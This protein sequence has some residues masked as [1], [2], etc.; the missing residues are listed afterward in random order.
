MATHVW[1]AVVALRHH[2]NGKL[3]EH[4]K[5]YQCSGVA[6]CANVRCADLHATSSRE[7]CTIGQD[8][9]TWTVSSVKKPSMEAMLTLVLQ[10]IMCASDARGV[11][12]EIG[13][14]ACRHHKHA[15]TK[16]YALSIAGWQQRKGPSS[17]NVAWSR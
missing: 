7:W 4:S 13:E 8:S 17:I 15:H 12:Q 16:G 11:P 14:A 1:L 6:V 2:V 3:P 5:L 10:A 9:C